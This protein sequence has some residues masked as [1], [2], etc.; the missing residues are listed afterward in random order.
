VTVLTGLVAHVIGNLE[1][2]VNEEH[3]SGNFKNL[4]WL[5]KMYMRVA[6]IKRPSFVEHV[7]GNL[8]VAGEE[9][10]VSGNLEKAKLSGTCDWQ[11]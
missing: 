8:D 2:A 3:V 6:I 10:H 4:K 7:I 1:E 5:V 11:S 9:E